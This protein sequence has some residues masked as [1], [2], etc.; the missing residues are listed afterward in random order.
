M[1]NKSYPTIN[2]RTYRKSE[3]LL[4]DTEYEAINADSN[5]TFKVGH[6]KFSDWSRD[7]FLKF[8]TGSL[9]VTKS[10]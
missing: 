6:N 4:K 5:N 3:W 7:E 10:D 1:Y 8:A 2:V 9:W